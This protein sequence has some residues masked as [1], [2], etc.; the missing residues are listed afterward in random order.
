[1]SKSDQQTPK[2]PEIEPTEPYVEEY[3]RDEVGRLLR[4]YKRKRRK[5][6]RRSK[7]GRPWTSSLGETSA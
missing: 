4:K 7:P 1:M 3:V 2:P 6:K 5:L